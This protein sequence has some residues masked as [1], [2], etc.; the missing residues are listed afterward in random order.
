MCCVVVRLEFGIARCSHH[1]LLLAPCLTVFMV[2]YLSPPPPPPPSLS[3]SHTLNAVFSTEGLPELETNLE[4]KF[5]SERQNLTLPC[6]VPTSLPPASIQ[7]EFNQAIL[8]EPALNSGQTG[9][10]LSGELVISSINVATDSGRFY[11]FV[12]NDVIDNSRTY[13]TGYLVIGESHV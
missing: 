6:T 11:C 2:P 13:T 9:I 8:D 5:V 1:L 3:L 12:S 4:R 10:T 7:W